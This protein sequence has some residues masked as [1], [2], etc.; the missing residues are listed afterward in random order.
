ME[1]KN[2]DF[3]RLD[4]RHKDLRPEYLE[5][6]KEAKEKEVEWRRWCKRRIPEGIHT[7]VRPSFSDLLPRLGLT[8]VISEPLA[9]ILETGRLSRPQV[10]KQ[11]WVY[12]KD[13]ALQNP[14][15]KRE[16]MCDDQLRAV[17]GVDKIDMFKMNK[18]LG[19]CVSSMCLF[20]TCLCHN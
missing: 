4:Y 13:N 17:F 7:K 16:I 2:R 6:T 10:V 11:L 9:A 20:L 1:W 8:A 12:I 19:Q 3:I 18:V 15:N 5:K 14:S